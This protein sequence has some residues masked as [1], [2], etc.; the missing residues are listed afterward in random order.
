MSL[1]YQQNERKRE[2]SSKL[3][4]SWPATWNVSLTTPTRLVTELDY[5]PTVQRCMD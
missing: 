3:I 1:H 5:Q 2:F 4:A